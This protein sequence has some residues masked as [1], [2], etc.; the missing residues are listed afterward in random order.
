MIQELVV[1]IPEDAMSGEEL[2]I[3]IPRAA[4]P[5]P[6]PKAMHRVSGICLRQVEERPVSRGTASRG[7]V[8]ASLDGKSSK[9]LKIDGSWMICLYGCAI[10]G[11]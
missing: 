6:A 8:G 3:P 10:P 9:K 4:T 5:L 7:T 11:F 1:T 2:E